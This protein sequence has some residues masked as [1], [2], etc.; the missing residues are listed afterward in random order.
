MQGLSFSC[1]ELVEEIKERKPGFKY[2]YQP[3]FRD[4]IAKDWPYSLDDKVARKDWG[5]SPK[6]KDVKSLADTMFSSIRLY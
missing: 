5:W 6:C 3:D 4:K 2:L 1:E